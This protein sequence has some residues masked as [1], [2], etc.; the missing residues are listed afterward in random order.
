MN[1]NLRYLLKTRTFLLLFLIPF[2]LVI[3]IFPYLLYQDFKQIDARSVEM[4]TSS[5]PK[6]MR[7]QRSYIN[8]ERLTFSLAQMMDAQNQSEA[9]AAYIDATAVVSEVIFDGSTAESDVRRLASNITKLWRQRLRIEKM[10]ESIFAT[11]YEL[12]EISKGLDPNLTN[13]FLKPEVMQPFLGILYFKQVL[14]DRISIDKDPRLQALL[15]LCEN[16]DTFRCKSL[17]STVDSFVSQVNLHREQVIKTQNLINK[18]NE[19]TAYLKSVLIEKEIDFISNEISVIQ[20]AAKSYEP[21]MV[22]FLSLIVA[23][24]IVFTLLSHWILVKPLQQIALAI[25]KFNRDEKSSL[26]KTNVYELKKILDLLSHLFADVIEKN[27]EHE[28]ISKENEKLVNLSMQDGLTK[29]LNR[30]SYE[31]YRLQ[32]PNFKVH[33]AILMIDIDHFKKLNDSM[34]HQKGDQTLQEVAKT[35]KQNIRPEDKVFRY[36]GE[37]F[38]IILK[39]ISYQD[40]LRRAQ[41]LC[42]AVRDLKLPNVGVQGQVTISVGFYYVDDEKN[43]HI[44]QS[45]AN[46]DAALYE[47]KESGRDRVGNFQDL[48]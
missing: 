4:Q 12:L 38:C 11:W 41:E 39:N 47:A 32:N 2:A 34:G 30:R 16:K 21:L 8:V 3:G 37:E 45:L 31:I 48:Q 27:L 15:S 19:Q 40:A 17:N 10:R 14:D 28:K 26:P 36:G 9:R 25:S 18:V 1:S 6:I 46:A 33:C 24:I 7:S 35:L 23:F 13:E 43:S 42:K 22:T 44:D 20:K 5:V 29:V